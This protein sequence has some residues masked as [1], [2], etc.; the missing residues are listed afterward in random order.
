M[1]YGDV[2]VHV[3]G[4]LCESVAGCYWHSFTEGCA[5]RVCGV[6]YAAEPRWSGELRGMGAEVKSCEKYSV[7]AGDS[8]GFIRHLSSEEDRVD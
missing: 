1:R 8:G 7:L 3:S 5:D 4:G 6:R 2:N